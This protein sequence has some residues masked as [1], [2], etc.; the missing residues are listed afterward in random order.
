MSGKTIIAFVALAASS[1]SAATATIVYRTI[2]QPQ[3]VDALAAGGG[4]ASGQGHA[5]FSVVTNAS[6]SF[7]KPFADSDAESGSPACLSDGDSQR[8][9]SGLH[10]SDVRVQILGSTPTFPPIWLGGD[11]EDQYTLNSFFRPAF[12]TSSPF[13]L[14]VQNKINQPT[15]QTG[16]S[17][18]NASQTDGVQAIRP[19][20]PLAN[21]LDGG[22]SIVPIDQ[23][24]LSP[25]SAFVPI[26]ALPVAEPLIGYSPSAI[27][28]PAAPSAPFSPSAIPAPSAPSAPF[29]PISSGPGGGGAVP[30]PSTWVMMLAG[31]ASLWFA[32]YRASGKRNRLGGVGELF[33]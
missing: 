12:D 30:E 25:L 21:I 8:C 31:F 14:V 13:G 17:D 32:G 3:H 27:P 28:A 33:S 4:G 19:S 10:G 6:E 9:A 23:L 20:P 26:D 2:F 5:E 24:G 22:L 7:S 29:W 11:S 16:A 1:A 15:G 18:Q